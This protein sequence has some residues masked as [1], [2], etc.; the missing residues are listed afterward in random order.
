MNERD[1]NLDRLGTETEPNGLVGLDLMSTTELVELM[2]RE[3][4]LVPGAV[5]L[6][7]D[8]VALAI[9]GIVD[10]L[11]GPGGLIY[12]G[13][14]S[15]G[16]L[17]MLDASECGPTFD[18]GP[19]RIQTVLAGGETALVN[20]SEEVEDDAEA[21]AADLSARS[22]SVHDAVV[23]ISASGRTPYVLGAL[24]HAH[25]K[26]ALTL[27]LV[28]NPSSPIARQ[29][30][31]PIE[32]VT[33]PEVIG[34]STRL[35]AGTAQ[36]LVLNMISTITMVRLGRT[37]GNLMVGVRGSNEKQRFRARRIIRLASG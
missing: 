26:K 12:V 36:K 28:C 37:F 24:E 29:V 31:L 1:S 7:R 18:V 25:G 33:G 6:A 30:D 17:A 35:K 13:A 27:G 9:D 21:G 16:R 34:G 3:D 2:N 32:I 8:Q 4:A 19:E 10:R 20:A 15:S 22:V 23:G 11:R 5:A 14:G